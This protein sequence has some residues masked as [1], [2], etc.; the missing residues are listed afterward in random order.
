MFEGS[1]VALITPFKK[2]GEVDDEKLIHLIKWHIDNKTDAIVVCG[3]TGESP[4]LSQTE[5]LKIF[6]ISVKA[7]ENKIPIIANTGTNNTLG[8]VEITQQ[9]KE[10]GVD[11]CM[12][13]VPY[14][15]RPTQE[16]CIEHFKM[17]ANVGLQTIIYHHPKRTG[18]NLT[19]DT[20]CKLEK[21][22]NIV[23]IKEAS[24]DLK[25]F[26]ELIEKCSIPILSGDDSLTFEMMKKGAKGV[27]S[28]VANIIPN[29]WKNLVK[30]CLD[31][32]YAEAEVVNNELVEICK[33][34]T[35]ETNPQAV[36]YAAHLINKCS[37]FLR[38][39]LIIPRNETMNEIEKA[40][41]NLS[42]I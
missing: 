4:T 25:F 5:K 27:I 16:G 36:K 42:I 28:V 7:S 12:A 23:A 13:V 35:L 18:A 3:T 9:A 19:I 26:E 38:L 10:I 20:F 31:K 24:S 37:L 34:M 14:Y 22:K 29:K 30:L 11:G 2:N 15:N 17:I 8:S 41:K 40:M 32:N 33:A 6:E 39:P 1:L 21:I